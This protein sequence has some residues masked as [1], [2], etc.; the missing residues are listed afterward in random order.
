LGEHMFRLGRVLKFD[1]EGEKSVGDAE[2]DAPLTRK[3][4]EP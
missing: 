3:C 4:R 2:A 1:A